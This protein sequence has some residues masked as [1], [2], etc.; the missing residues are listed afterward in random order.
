MSEKNARRRE[1]IRAVCALADQPRQAVACPHCDHP[2]L[3][4]KYLPVGFDKLDRHV[5]C[6]ACGEESYLYGFIRPCEPQP[7]RKLH[8]VD[9]GGE[10]ARGPN[11][12]YECLV[13]GA[14]LPSEPRHGLHCVCRN[15]SID[16]GQVSIRDSAKAKFF[17][18]SD[19][20]EMKPDDERH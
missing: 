13:C 6:I 16:T 12:L 8:D 17:T 3:S 18:V 19:G 14:M 9:P 20:S 1:W 2:S 4:I 10:Y 7:T 15:I 11:L 5:F